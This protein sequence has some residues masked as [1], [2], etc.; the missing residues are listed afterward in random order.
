MCVARSG[1]QAGTCGCMCAISP[2]NARVGRGRAGGQL[3]SARPYVSW[4]RPVSDMFVLSVR[5][6]ASRSRESGKRSNELQNCNT[7]TAMTRNIAGSTADCILI[8]WQ[9]ILKLQHLENIVQFSASLLLSFFLSLPV[10]VSSMVFLFNSSS[11]R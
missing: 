7:I 1:V 3:S 10:P 5:T 11:A 8:D 9:F 4:Q 6:V 2:W